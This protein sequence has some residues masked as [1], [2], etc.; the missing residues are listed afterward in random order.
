[1]SE[2]PD[3]AEILKGRSQSILDTVAALR[4]VVSTT[5]PA[6][7]ESGQVGS[8]AISYS[9]GEVSIIPQSEY[10]NLQLLRGALLDDPSGLL[11]GTGKT[12]RHVKIRTSADAQNPAVAQLLLAVVNLESSTK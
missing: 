11:E 12:M 10:V 4:Q 1:M 5:I 2:D 3:I 9:K 6:A 7:K 8:N